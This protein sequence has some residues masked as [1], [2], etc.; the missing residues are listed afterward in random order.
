VPLDPRHVLFRAGGERFALPLESVSE[1]A[2]PQPPFA[3]VPRTPAAVRGAMNLRGRVVVV[4]ELAPLL[5]LA[6][7][8][9]DDGQGQVVVLERERRVL[10]FLVEGV[11]GVEAVEPTEPASGGL[12]RGV[13]RLQGGPVPVLDPDALAEAA[14]RLFGERAEGQVGDRP[15]GPLP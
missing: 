5:G 1:V 12:V 7:A 10:G 14:R 9:I 13:A 6:A 2:T 8:P 15:T 11:L 3:R 4:V